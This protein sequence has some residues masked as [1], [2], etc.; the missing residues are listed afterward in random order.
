M[1]KQKSFLSSH[2]CFRLSVYSYQVTDSQLVSP[3]HDNQTALHCNGLK[4]GTV[5]HYFLH[6]ALSCSAVLSTLPHITALQFVVWHHMEI[7][8]PVSH[9]TMSIL[10][11]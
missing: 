2:V 11:E 8:C 10:V 7:Y 3:A 1:Y 4:H 5:L 6:P 9:H